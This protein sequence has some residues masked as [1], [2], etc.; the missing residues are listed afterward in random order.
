MKKLLIFLALGGLLS[1]F[2]RK[3]LTWTAIG[4]SITYLNDHTNETGDR[5]TKG[6]LTRITDK[7]PYIHYTNQGHNGWTA[8]RM[9]QS[10]ETLGL[11]KA[12]IYSVFLGTNDWW[13]GKPLGRFADYQTNTGTA[14]V[15]GAFRIIIDK[16]RSLNPQAHIVLITPMQRADFV[17]LT[18]FKNNAFGSY[19]PKNGQQL[20]SFANAVDSIGRFEQVPVLDLYHLKSLDVKQ[21]VKYKR[22]KNPQTGV[23]TNYKYPAFIDVPFNPEA[24]EYPYPLEAV[25]K[26]YDGLHPSD[27]GYALITRGLFKIMKKY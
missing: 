25:D 27:K 6:Y 19:K 1:S 22:L 21:L 24:D 8:I 5:I 7:L 2:D 16:L 13:A 3:E 18:N 15:Y 23:Y 14:T 26:T 12:D 17:Y 4:D 10:I 20:E 9:A 11:G